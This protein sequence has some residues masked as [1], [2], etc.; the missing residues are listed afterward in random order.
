MLCHDRL[1]LLVEDVLQREEHF[2][3]QSPACNASRG[4]QVAGYGGFC[5]DVTA[6]YSPGE[7]QRYL[8]DDERQSVPSSARE[9]GA[10]T[11]TPFSRGSNFGVWSVNCA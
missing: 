6:V 7:P 1:S 10:G 11:S 5:E 4:T 8:A 9:S 3:P 2:L